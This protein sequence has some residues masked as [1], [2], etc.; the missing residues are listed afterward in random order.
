MRIE[1]S[2]QSGVHASLC[3]CHPA[4]H[5]VYPPIPPCTPPCLPRYT[6]CYTA[7]LPYPD[8]AGAPTHAGV[9]G[10][11]AP[12]RRMAWVRGLPVPP[13]VIPVE[14]SMPLG[15]ELLRSSCE[16]NVKDWIDE[17]SLPV[18]R[19]RVRHVAQRPP[20][21]LP[22]FKECYDAQ[23]GPPPSALPS[24]MSVMPPTMGPGPPFF[25]FLSRMSMLRRGLSSPLPVHNPGWGITGEQFPRNTPEESDDAQRGFQ[26]RGKQAGITGIK[27]GNNTPREGELQH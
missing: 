16:I 24:L 17:G 22:L 2:A 6:L 27:P 26:T 23:S 3:I 19:L 18:Y 1:A 9:R 14:D 15:A 8:A 13:G 20:F 25:I 7:V 4:H 12:T 10:R 21:L 5:G 11:G